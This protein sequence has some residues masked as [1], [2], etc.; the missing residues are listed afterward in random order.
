MTEKKLPQVKSKLP[1]WSKALIG[2]VILAFGGF[3]FL[4]TEWI[5]GVRNIVLNSTDKKNMEHCAQLV[6]EFPQPLPPEY[7]YTCGVDLSVINL[8][9][10][11][12]DHVPDKQKI[13]FLCHIRDSNAEID[14]KQ[15]LDRAYDFGIT[16][17]VAVCR[18]TDIKKKGDLQVGPDKMLYMTGNLKDQTGRIYEG[19]AGC[20]RSTAKRKTLFVYSLSQPGKALNLDNCFNLLKSLPSI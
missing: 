4:S 12:V 17:D 5:F 1:I 6:A 15:M 7:E 10:L 20:V 13:I 14:T 18:F 11:A 8:I 16:T 9:L 2:F 3:L 19:V